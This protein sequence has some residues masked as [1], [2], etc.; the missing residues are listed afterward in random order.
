[1]EHI[2]PNVVCSVFRHLAV[3]LERIVFEQSWGPAIQP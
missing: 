1:L 2:K 3:A